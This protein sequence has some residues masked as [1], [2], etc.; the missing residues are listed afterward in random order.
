MSPK[1]RILKKKTPMKNV[2]DVKEVDSDSNKETMVENKD[3]ENISISDKS[4]ELNPMDS[5]YDAP[6]PEVKKVTFEEFI[7]QDN[8][9]SENEKILEKIDEISITT[10]SDNSSINETDE[11]KIMEEFLLNVKKFFNFIKQICV[12]N[13]EKIE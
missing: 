1:K 6:E 4:S 13:N 11:C 3:S 10:E 12:P 5:N 7:N 2:T 8:D 9:E